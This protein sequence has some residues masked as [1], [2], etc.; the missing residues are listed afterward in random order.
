M[1]PLV[2]CLMKVTTWEFKKT[3]IL[4]FYML[5][6][7]AFFGLLLPLLIG[8]MRVQ[9]HRQL[10]YGDNSVLDTHS[11]GPDK[12]KETVSLIHPHNFLLLIQQFGYPAGIRFSRL[13]SSDRILLIVYF[14]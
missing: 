2:T 13:M 9:G 8:L 11:Y 7:S 12:L 4:F 10:V 3:R 6:G 14:L 1:A 5:P